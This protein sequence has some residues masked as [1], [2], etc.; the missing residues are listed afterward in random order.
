MD[1]LCWRLTIGEEA[2][3]DEADKKREKDGAE[4]ME[5]ERSPEFSVGAADQR[6]AHAAAGAGDVCENPNGAEVGETE[7]GF[8]VGAGWGN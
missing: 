6:A 5:P 7:Q 2:Q 3:D 4:R 8:V 1:E